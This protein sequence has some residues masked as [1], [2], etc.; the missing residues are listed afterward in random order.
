MVIIVSDVDVIVV[1][2]VSVV[3]LLVVADHIVLCC[4]Q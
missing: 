3:F 1:I 2:N 4:G